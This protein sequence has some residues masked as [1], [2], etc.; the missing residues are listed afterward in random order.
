MRVEPRRQTL[1]MSAVAINISNMSCL[2]ELRLSAVLCLENED[3]K[4]VDH[5]HDSILLQKCN[6]MVF[7]QNVVAASFSSVWLTR[8]TVIQA[9]VC[10]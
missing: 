1:I 5:A 7:T 9:L 6:S 4:I 3:I 8:Q 2:T 10:C